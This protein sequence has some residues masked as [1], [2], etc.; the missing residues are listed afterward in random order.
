MLRQVQ[1]ERERG[2]K[3]LRPAATAQRDEQKESVMQNEKTDE[4]ENA[5]ASGDAD[6]ET[7]PMFVTQRE[8]AADNEKFWNQPANQTP[9][10]AAQGSK[11]PAGIVYAPPASNLPATPISVSDLAARS[12]KGA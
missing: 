9:E 12:R 4:I 8:L 3:P 1:E 10:P 6:V 5:P 7:I 11:S 2:R